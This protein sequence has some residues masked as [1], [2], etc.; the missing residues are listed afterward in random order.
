MKTPVSRVL[1]TLGLF[2]ILYFQLSTVSAQGTALTVATFSVPKRSY[3]QWLTE[4]AKS[5]L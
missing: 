5:N 1:V 4:Q 3:E 2:S